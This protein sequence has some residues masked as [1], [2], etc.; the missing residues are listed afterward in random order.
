MVEIKTLKIDFVFLVFVKNSKRQR[1]YMGFWKT[2]LIMPKK[3]IITD[4]E[5]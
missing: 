3:K 2:T 4:P 1:S 5:F